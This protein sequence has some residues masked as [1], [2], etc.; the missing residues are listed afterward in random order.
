MIKSLHLAI[1]IVILTNWYDESIGIGLKIL[2]TI[3]AVFIFIALI[4]NDFLKNKKAREEAIGYFSATMDEI[5]NSL[6]KVWNKYQK[7]VKGDHQQRRVVEDINPLHTVP[8]E[9]R[10]MLPD[11]WR[12]NVTK[13]YPI[14]SIFSKDERSQIDKFCCSLIKIVSLYERIQNLGGSSYDANHLLP[15]LKAQWNELVP[16]TLER[17]NPLNTHIGIGTPLTRCPSHTT[18]HTGPYCAVRLIRQNQ[19]Q[20]NIN[21]SD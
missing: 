4:I 1:V 3:L 10:P 11:D 15:V 19:I 21:Q 17:G 13:L 12:W 8:I 6:H 5:L 14:P 16:N 20:G 18:Q 7:M 9:F 2:I